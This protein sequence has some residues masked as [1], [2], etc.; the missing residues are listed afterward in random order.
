MELIV[1]FWCEV[2]VSNLSVIGIDLSK[3]SNVVV[4]DLSVIFLGLL[5][6]V[7]GYGFV[8]VGDIGGVI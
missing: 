6:K 7:F 8:I 5:V 4:V 2:G 1:Y 3:E